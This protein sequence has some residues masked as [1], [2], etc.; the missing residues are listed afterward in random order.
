MGDRGVI[1]CGAKEKWFCFSND[2]ERVRFSPTLY[3]HWYGYKNAIEK[4]LI[5]SWKFLK[6]LQ[7]LHEAWRQ[8]HFVADPHRAMGIITHIAWELGYEPQL[9][10]D[11]FPLPDRDPYVVVTTPKAWFITK[12]DFCNEVY[13][14]DEGGLELVEPDKD[15]WEVVQKAMDQFF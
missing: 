3:T 5:E 6:W 7:F 14:I 11:E 15:V 8:D 13:R 12:G 1:V 2:G 4:L 10:G 9:F